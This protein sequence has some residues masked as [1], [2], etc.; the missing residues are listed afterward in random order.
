MKI[1]VTGGAGFIGANFLNRLVPDLPEHQ[2]VNLDKLTYAANLGSL[3]EIE[4]LPNYTL[5][6]V[7]ITDMDGV[8][9]VF[10]EF[11]P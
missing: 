8:D 6:R 10:D 2:F 1:M 5:R 7:D 9:A 3:R 11:D 4:A